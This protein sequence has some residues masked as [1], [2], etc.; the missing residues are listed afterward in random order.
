MEKTINDHVLLYFFSSVQLRRLLAKSH[1]S[2][3]LALIQ[4]PKLPF[5]YYN[6]CGDTMAVNCHLLAKTVVVVLLVINPA[7]VSKV[8]DNSIID[9]KR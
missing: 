2:L 5:V 8:M 6:L 1:D 9:Q 3:L 4:D 7:R